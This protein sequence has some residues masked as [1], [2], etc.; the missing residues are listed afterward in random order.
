MLTNMFKLMIC[1]LASLLVVDHIKAKCRV[2]VEWK[3]E[4]A[5]EIDG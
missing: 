4:T 5:L 2:D 3:D 1:I